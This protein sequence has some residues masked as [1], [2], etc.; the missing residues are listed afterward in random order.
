MQDNE[1]MTDAVPFKGCIWEKKAKISLYEL[2]TR[3][4]RI[5]RTMLTMRPV[6]V[7]MTP[8]HNKL[9]KGNL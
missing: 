1:T 2:L 7:M 8:N 4:K 9:I 5:R 6:A 3:F